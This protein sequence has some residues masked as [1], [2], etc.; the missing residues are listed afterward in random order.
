MNA[1]EANVAVDGATAGPLPADSAQPAA[2][3]LGDLARD[4]GAFAKAW[5]R[6][7]TSEAALARVNLVRIV[8]VALLV[9]AIAIGIV[10][11]VNGIVVSLLYALSQ[12]WPLAFL[13]ATVLNIAI[14]AWMLW[15][16]RNWWRTLSLPRSRKALTGLWSKKN[17]L[18]TIGE[19]QDP[20]RGK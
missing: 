8:L 2:N 4:T 19:S 11:G 18:A 15:M 12:S 6:L 5:F 16:L 20:I 14:L 7:I 1:N 3:S 13:G 17:D 10:A 9:P